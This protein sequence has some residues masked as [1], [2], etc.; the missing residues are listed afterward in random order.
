ML[1]PSLVSVF[2]LCEVKMW[3]SCWD[4]FLTPLAVVREARITF[5]S[6]SHQIV[7][8]G[9]P[10]MSLA[11]WYQYFT[12]RVCV[13]IPM[14]V[15]SFYHSPEMLPE[16]T[17]DFSEWKMILIFVILFQECSLLLYVLFYYINIHYCLNCVVRPLLFTY[18]VI[19]TSELLKQK[20][21]PLFECYKNFELLIITNLLFLCSWEWCIVK[22]IIHCMLKVCFMY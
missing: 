10:C 22:V 5:P 18:W 17:G 3:W 14:C 20:L 12:S 6:S 7:H 1:L 2:S 21:C 19:F 16:R 15:Y 9:H 8:S 11:D 13:Y 4:I